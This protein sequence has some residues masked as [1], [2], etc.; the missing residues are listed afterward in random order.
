M[1]TYVLRLTPAGAHASDP[2][3]VVLGAVVA[4]PDSATARRT[5]QTEFREKVAYAN[6][7]ATPTW[8][9]ASLTSCERLGTYGGR[10]QVPFVVLRDFNAG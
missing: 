7:P 1:N 6:N 10:K 2:H 3:D 8:T 9:T 4:A 5:A